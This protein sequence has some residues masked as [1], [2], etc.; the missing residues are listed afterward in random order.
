MNKRERVVKGYYKFKKRLKDRGLWGERD[1]PKFNLNCFRT[2]G[3]PCSCVCCSEFKYSRK[4][5]HIK[6]IQEE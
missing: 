1:N 4:E 6:K 3:K 5:K 2:T